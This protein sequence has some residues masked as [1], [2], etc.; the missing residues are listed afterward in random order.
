MFIFMCLMQ[1]QKFAFHALARDKLVSVVH[2]ERPS[3]RKTHG[4]FSAAP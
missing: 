2:L 1:S 3:V 4:I